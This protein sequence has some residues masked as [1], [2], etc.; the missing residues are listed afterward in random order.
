M[1]QLQFQ[2]KMNTVTSW[3]R[4][5]QFDKNGYL[6]IHDLWDAE[7]LFRPVPEERGQIKYWGKKEDQYTFQESEGQVEGSLATY[8]HPQYRLSLIHI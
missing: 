7:D 8:S 1:Q 4:N 2:E 5:E 3:T 6:I